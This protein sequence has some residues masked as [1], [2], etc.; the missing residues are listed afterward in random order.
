MSEGNIYLIHAK[1]TESYKIGLTTRT[2]KE[3][4]K[5]LNGKQ[6][7]FELVLRHSI[8]VEKVFV[9]EKHFHTK[10]EK[11]NYHNEW[12]TFS[13]A[14]V[15]EVIKYMTSYQTE[16]QKQEE[17]RNQYK[18]PVLEIDNQ[19]IQTEDKN[20]NQYKNS[21]LEI[22][23]QT[24]QIENENPEIKRENFIL[25]WISKI[26]MF[27]FYMLIYL[28]IIIFE[29]IKVLFQFRGVIPK[30]MFWVKKSIVFAF[31]AL[32]LPPMFLIEIIKGLFKMWRAR[33]KKSSFII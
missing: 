7:P 24:I 8:K 21:I 13:E 15:C 5:E 12:F 18:N 6:S 16:N 29:F 26:L 14:E 25:S 1:G 22:D 17:N 30:I 4:L 31:Y 19:I 33:T 9:A 32:F 3:R 2:T 20:R 10:Y 28:P 27:F 23:N 11:C